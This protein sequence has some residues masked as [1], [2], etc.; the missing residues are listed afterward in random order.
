MTEIAEADHYTWWRNALEG[1]K[2]PIKDGEPQAGFY[3]RRLVRGGPWIPIAIFPDGNGGMYA[4]QGRD[5]AEV[6]NAVE[7]WPYCADNPVTEAAA[8]KAAADGYW[9]GELPPAETSETP[10]DARLGIGGNF[11]PPDKETD[12]QVLERLSTPSD[13]VRSKIDELAIETAKA[14]KWYEETPVQTKEHADLA[15]NWADRL[16]GLNKQVEEER[17]SLRRPFLDRLEKIQNWFKPTQDAAEQVIKALDAAARK[18][19]RE[20]QQRLEEE[21]RRKAEEERKR[22]EEEARKLR[23]EQEQKLK[24]QGLDPAQVE[25]PVPLPPVEEPKVIVPKVMVGGAS[26]RRRGA[27]KTKEDIE[28]VDIKALLLHLQDHPDIVALA[29]KIARIQALKGGIK[30]PGVKVVEVPA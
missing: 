6:V 3:R 10:E 22:R 27:S 12:E 9:P 30:V 7:I 26:G 28:I 17:K 15:A 29:T 5:F 21:A 14:K 2:G 16:S 18:W 8:R 25:L 1:N 11:P 23:E 24:E 19:A 13:D 20:E 4:R